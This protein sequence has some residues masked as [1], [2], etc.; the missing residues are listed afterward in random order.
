MKTLKIVLYT[1]ITAAIIYSAAMITVFSVV[2]VKGGEATGVTTSA[3]GTS[4]GNLVISLPEPVTNIK[5]DTPI[6]TAGTT[7]SVGTLKNVTPVDDYYLIQVQTST[8]EADVNNYTVSSNVQKI[9]AQIPVIGLIPGLIQKSWTAGVVLIVFLSISAIMLAKG[10]Y[11]K[12]IKPIPVSENQIKVL[13]TFFDQAPTPP[14]K[15]DIKNYERKL[16]NA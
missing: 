1:I 5:N 16:K 4:L 12:K 7:T 10:F 3:Y 8:S 2:A 9:Y 13:Q 14:T 15:Q 11:R 6:L